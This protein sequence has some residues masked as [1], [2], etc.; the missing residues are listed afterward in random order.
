M[1]AAAVLLTLLLM[2]ACDEGSVDVPGASN[3][4]TPV[5]KKQPV[6]SGYVVDEAGRPV[7]GVAV[8]VFTP[9]KVND[10]QS[11]TGLTDETGHFEFDV[12]GELGIE[13]PIPLLL[14]LRQEWFLPSQHQ[15]SPWRPGRARSVD[16]TLSPAGAVTGRVV[17]QD[18]LP[19]AGAFVFALPPDIP[20]VNSAATVPSTRTDA[21]G[22]FR[23]TGLPVRGM[24]VGVLA[25]G[26]T[27][28]LKGP[29]NVL[30]GVDVAFGGIT[31]GPGGRIAGEVRTPAGKPVAGAVVRGFRDPDLRDFE[32]FGRATVTSAGATVRTGEDG[33]F[34]MTTLGPGSYTVEA[35]AP[36][37]RLA[38]SSVRDVP[39][40]RADLRLTLDPVVEIELL[41]YDAAAMQPVTA[42][43][44]ISVTE[45]M[46]MK[47]ETR[48]EV[49][50]RDGICRLVAGE[51][52]T[53]RVTIA[54]EGYET[55]EMTFTVTEDFDR[56][57]RIPLTKR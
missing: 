10:R 46:E 20:G 11:L 1:K 30:P 39:P 53:C 22:G 12:E 32:L 31:L 54:A 18:D 40:G 14:D 50:S 8:R 29:V 48:E 2:T 42:Y 19:V 33:R 35:V 56:S 24:D 55:H 13:Q 16:I 15:L 38:A 44:V 49:R 26:F 47:P 7:A 52:A 43:T 17:N 23:L 9:I 36:G 37:H 3:R 41:V 57:L 5:R 6:L 25:E 27:P 34:E 4:L 21:R 45:S 28:A 51:G